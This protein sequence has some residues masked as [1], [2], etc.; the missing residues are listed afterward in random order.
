MKACKPYSMIAK[1]Y[2]KLMRYVPY[3]RWAGYIDKI[4]RKFYPGARTVLDVA[5][6]TGTMV[7]LLSKLGYRVDGLDVSEEMLR[8]A[9][10][11]IETRF[12]LADMRNFST[13]VK[14]DAVV[15]LYDSVNYLLSD[16][17]FLSFLDSVY[18]S[19][20]D[21]LLVFDIATEMNSVK[22]LE[23]MNYTGRIGVFKFARRSSYD[24]ALKRHYTE[25][26]IEF[27]GEIFCERHEQ[28][29]YKISEIFDLVEKHGG[30]DLLGCF[31]GL[32]FNPGSEDST[33]VHF[34]LRKSGG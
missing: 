26:V 13:P 20:N 16:H 10:G 11:K 24:K 27:N 30:F 2:D 14:Y 21:G 17:D 18:S 19:I 3:R 31:D 29:I 4:L 22:N 33:R 1:I 6:G 8:I 32:T 34:V 5:C 12:Y 7:V 15:C 28:R 25:F 9:K 23:F